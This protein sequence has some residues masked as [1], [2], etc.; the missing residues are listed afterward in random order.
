RNKRGDHGPDIN[1]MT[2]AAL[3]HTWIRDSLQQ[4]KPYN[5]FVR[6]IVTATGDFLGDN[7]NPPVAW[8][9]HLFKP[10]TLADDTAQVFLGTQINCAQCHHH[11]YEKWSQDDYWSLAAFFARINWE[12]AGGVRLAVPEKCGK[13]ISVGSKGMA[14]SPQG[15]SYSQPHALDAEP[16]TVP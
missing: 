6:E 10:E 14:R 4:N 7:P 15:K 16:P 11:P 3:F 12:P 13:R 8:Y 1:S 2:R 9:T 5:Q